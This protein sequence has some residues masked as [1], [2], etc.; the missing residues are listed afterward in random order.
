M[1][2]ITFAVSEVAVKDTAD[3]RKA[4][5]VLKSAGP[6]GASQIKLQAQEDLADA[7]KVGQF[8]EMSLK[9]VSAPV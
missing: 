6:K 5:I 8:Y 9:E 4:V 3:G 2:S 7:Y 1:Q